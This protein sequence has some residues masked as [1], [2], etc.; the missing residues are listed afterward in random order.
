MTPPLDPGNPRQLDLLRSL[1]EMRDDRARQRLGTAANS[2]TVKRKDG[3][4]VTFGRN[5]DDRSLADRGG[6]AAMRNAIAGRVGAQT[7]ARAGHMTRAGQEAATHASHA[8]TRHGYQTGWTGQLVRVCT[9][10]APDQSYDPMGLGVVSR[11]WTSGEDAV[12]LGMGLERM[13]VPGTRTPKALDAHGRPVANPGGAP[14][15]AP[16]DDA[17]VAG[18][19][20]S[21]FADPEAQ[22]EAIARAKVV[23]DAQRQWTHAASKNPLSNHNSQWYWHDFLKIVVTVQRPGKPLGLIMSRT[24]T[25]RLR[26]RAEVEAEIDAFYRGDR[27]LSTRG[28]ALPDVGTFAENQAYFDSVEND[29]DEDRGGTAS[30]L[31]GATSGLHRLKYPNLEDLFAALGVQATAATYAKVVFKRSAVGQPW[32]V[33][34]A[35]PWTHASAAAGWHP[36]VGQ[37]RDW[38]GKQWNGGAWEAGL[39]SRPNGPNWLYGTSAVPAWM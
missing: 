14:P 13:P 5:V 32:A 33:L 24:P 29:P 4:T 28:A 16:V 31:R 22:A 17:P 34:T 2:N 7:A 23:A 18:R 15:P 36:D 25:W 11:H 39:M 19:E 10:L 35:F 38:R 30:Y 3:T 26:T 20:A 27:V 6:V 37:G 1:I 21:M 12:T 9:Q 8:H